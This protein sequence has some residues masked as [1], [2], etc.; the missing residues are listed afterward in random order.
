MKRSNKKILTEGGEYNTGFTLVELLAVIVILA[1]ILVIA[2]PRIMDTITKVKENSLIS[3]AKLIINTGE[4]KYIE[5]KAL[6]KEDVITCSDI[7]SLSNN[8][9][10][11]C[12]VSFDNDGK[13]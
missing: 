8:D 4:K 3:S 6:N 12:N 5:N 2:V 7:T 1:V 9:Y 10:S 11:Y 13:A